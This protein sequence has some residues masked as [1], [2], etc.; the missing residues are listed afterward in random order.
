MLLLLMMIPRPIGPRGGKARR[1]K[2]KEARKAT[3]AS[4]LTKVP[5]K[6]RHM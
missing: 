1:V 6:R 4:L 2:E 5:L 3:R